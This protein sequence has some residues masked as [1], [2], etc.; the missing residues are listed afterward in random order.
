MIILE[1]AEPEIKEGATYDPNLLPDHCGNYFQHPKV[2]LIQ[3]LYF[4]IN[5]SLIALWRTYQTLKTGTVVLVDCGISCWK[6]KVGQGDG[7]CKVRNI[8]I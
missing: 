4:D 8:F 7:H 5:K 6:I 3:Q 2:C 1:H